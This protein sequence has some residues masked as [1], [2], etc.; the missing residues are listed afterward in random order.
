[1]DAVEEMVLS[2]LDLVGKVLHKWYSSLKAEEMDCGYGD[3]LVGLWEAAKSFKPQSGVP[4]GK[5]ATL[6]IHYAVHNGR[7]DRKY[8]RRK[9]RDLEYP[10]NIDPDLLPDPH[11][12][13]PLA[14]LLEKDLLD[15]AARNCSHLW[16]M[17]GQ[18]YIGGLQKDY[19][20]EAGISDDKAK[21]RAHRFRHTVREKFPR[22]IRELES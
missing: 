3:G 17:I 21:Q 2:N 11:P 6:K 20:A 16:P 5:W 22:L 18:L 19:A 1:M 15:F 13:N 4:F 9:N 8:A 12:D 14:A 10:G 7:R